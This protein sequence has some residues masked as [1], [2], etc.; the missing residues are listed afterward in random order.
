M[1]TDT[2]NQETWA[3]TLLPKNVIGTSLVFIYMQLP[4][5]L[6]GKIS[7]NVLPVLDWII[8]CHECGLPS[9]K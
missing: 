8:S 1:L 7:A 5:I 9:D 2:Q 6:I 3:Q 4:K